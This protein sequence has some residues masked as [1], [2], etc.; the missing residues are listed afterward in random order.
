DFWRRWHMTL[1]RFLRDY[2]YISLGGNRRGKLRRY[3]NLFITMAL[4]G[5]W[6]GP[7]WTF[8]LWGA[9][10][11]LMLIVNHGWNALPIR[12][13]NTWWSR[14]FARALTFLC[15]ALAWVLFRAA[16]LDAAMAIYRGLA[17][18]P[19]AP[20][21][22]RLGEDLLW[23]AFWMGIVWF[24]PNTQQWLA[25]VRPAF[26]YNWADRRADPLLLPVEGTKFLH[27]FL[28]R[29]SKRIAVGVGLAAAASFLSLQR[30]SEFLYFQF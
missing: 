2:L 8:M 30:V 7:A 23:L 10:H 29:P 12:K 20:D 5:L 17:A 28:W 14:G 18:V 22:A 6:H 21:L 15:V 27:V 11:G 9:A 26:N 1:S 19:Y 4:G 3:L 13:I 25:M 24:W 16:D